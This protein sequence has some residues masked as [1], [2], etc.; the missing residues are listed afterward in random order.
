MAKG[1]TEYPPIS[2]PKLILVEG[3]DEE[4]VFFRNDQEDRACARNGRPPDSW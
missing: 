2:K 1:K 3:K 4:S